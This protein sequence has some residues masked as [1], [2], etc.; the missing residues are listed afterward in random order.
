MEFKAKG[1]EVN[2]SFSLALYDSETDEDSIV[3][4]GDY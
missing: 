1:W 3:H 2:K 4:L